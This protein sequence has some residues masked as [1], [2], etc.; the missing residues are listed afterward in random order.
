MNNNTI[1]G[2]TASDGPTLNGFEP[3]G[4]GMFSVSNNIVWDGDDDDVDNT[5]ANAAHMIFANNDIGHFARAPTSS[6]DINEDPQF[7]D[8]ANGNYRLMGASPARDAGENSPPGGTLT[9]DLDGNTRVIGIVDM[10]AYEI[11]DEIFS[12][13]FEG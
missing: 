7:V 8:P 6:G 2:N 12:D 1:A 5:S 9:H 3:N 13:G 11:P 4:K 10:G